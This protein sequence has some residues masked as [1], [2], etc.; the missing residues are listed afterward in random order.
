MLEPPLKRTEGKLTILFQQIERVILAIQN[1][2]SRHDFVYGVGGVRL[3]K[4][5]DPS[6]QSLCDPLRSKYFPVCDLE[7]NSEKL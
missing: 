3:S 1:S 4:T 6:S 5:L 2:L 7:I